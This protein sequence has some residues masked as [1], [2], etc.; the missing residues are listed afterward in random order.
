MILEKKVQNSIRQLLRN[1]AATEVM[2]Y[3]LIFVIKYSQENFIFRINND[4]K[5]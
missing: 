1:M 4:S 2:T 5:I 3:T